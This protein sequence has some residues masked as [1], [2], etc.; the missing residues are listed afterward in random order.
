V[1]EDNNMG[2]CFLSRKDGGH[3]AEKHGPGAVVD[4]LLQD[5]LSKCA[6]ERELPCAV[7]FAV[8]KQLDVLP[9]VV[10]RAA[11]LM[12]LRIVKCQLGLFGYRPEKSIIRPAKSVHADLEKAILAGLVNNRLPCTTAWD[13]SRK[14]GIRKMKVSA[15]CDA[16]GIRIKPCQL[17][18]F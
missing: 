13:I 11:D 18:A 14:L 9:H 2:G 7:A 15:A 16:M 10:G 12:E 5:V 6:S 17:G 3:Y 4:S 1:S 8:A